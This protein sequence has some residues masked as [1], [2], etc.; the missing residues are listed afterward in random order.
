MVQAMDKRFNPGDVV[1]ADHFSEFDREAEKN[2]EYQIDKRL[3][4][5]AVKAITELFGS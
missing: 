2:L 5:D 1:V 4:D 3:S